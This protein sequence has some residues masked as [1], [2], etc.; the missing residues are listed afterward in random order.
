MNTTEIPVPPL[1][2]APPETITPPSPQNPDGPNRDAARPAAITWLAAT[3]TALLFAALA[4][5]TIV[6]WQSL[7]NWA[8]FGVLMAATAAALTAG[9]KMRAR[10]PVTAMALAHLGALL[11]PIDATAVAKSYTWSWPQLLI[12]QGLTGLGAIILL[13]RF[14]RSVVLDYTRPVAI[15]IGVVGFSVNTHT[16]APAIAAAIALSFAI[17]NRDRRGA[18]TLAAASAFAP[19]AL[20]VSDFYMRHADIAWGHGVATRAGI[21]NA[22]PQW[23]IATAVLTALALAVWAYRD[24]SIAL[25]AVAVGAF[26]MN[27]ALAL[28]ALPH[29]SMLRSLSIPALFVLFELVAFGFRNDQLFRKPTQHLARIGEV[30]AALPTVAI[31]FNAL[32]LLPIRATPS[33]KWGLLLTALAWSIAVAGDTD[34]SEDSTISQLRVVGLTAAGLAATSALV[35]NGAILAAIAFGLAVVATITRRSV[36]P[37]AMPVMT[38]SILAAHGTHWSPTFAAGATITILS[39]AIIEHRSSWLWFAVTPAALLEAFT[40]FDFHVQRRPMLL[41]VSCVGA[42]LMATAAHMKREWRPPVVTISLFSSAFGL[43]IATLDHAALFGTAL[44]ITGVGVLA[45]GL[46]ARNFMLG[47]VGGGLLLYGTWTTLAIHHV[48]PVEWYVLPLAAHLAIAGGLHRRSVIVSGQT[49]AATTTQASSW[50]AYA[51]A[52]LAAFAPSLLLGVN[53]GAKYHLLV[54]GIIAVIAVAIGAGKR[55]AA[56]LILGTTALVVITGDVVVSPARAVP[57]WVWLAAGGSTLIATAIGMER[58]HTTPL[59]AGRRLVDVV[60]AQFE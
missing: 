20:L 22:I 35:S 3:G 28:V 51:P 5:F 58:T 52:L 2:P 60:Q 37:I 48:N 57:S 50:T 32:M 23:H 42:A 41:I 19:V 17:A 1:P 47:N 43:G 4:V 18:L 13:Q 27:G 55:L 30:V 53:H 59:A 12:L 34:T 9:I 21:I 54:A 40:M 49:T 10:M 44:I 11:I 7:S 26:I 14:M 24:R 33:M 56:P 6:Q 31:G 15:G 29:Q 38:W 45:H 36:A 16:S 8:K 39:I 25:G 46:I